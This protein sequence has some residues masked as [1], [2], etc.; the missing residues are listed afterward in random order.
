MIKG[1]IFSEIWD[2]K[3]IVY[4]VK[5]LI[6]LERFF[7]QSHDLK[8][9]LQKIDDFFPTGILYYGRSKLGQLELLLLQ[10]YILLFPKTKLQI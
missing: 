4:L 10:N 1:A 8:S 9:Y 2:E 5:L 6:I 3:K 7:M